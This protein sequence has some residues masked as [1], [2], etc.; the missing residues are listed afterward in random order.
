[1]DEVTEGR[2]KLH[3]D[4]PHSLRSSPNIITMIKSRRVRCVLACRTHMGNNKCFKN[5]DWLN[6]KGSS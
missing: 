2:R 1:M 3:N 6:F 4:E 5:F